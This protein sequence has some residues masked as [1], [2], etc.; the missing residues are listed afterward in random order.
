MKAG[1]FLPLTIV[2]LLVVL[3]PAGAAAADCSANPCLH[4]DC[5]EEESA[6]SCICEPG[7][8]GALC[9]SA[10]DPGLTPA[11]TAT[12]V[13][14]TEGFDD[15]LG[16][17]GFRFVGDADA[18][19]AAASGGRLHLTSDGTQLYHGTDNG[20]L[21]SQTVT[22]DFRAEVQ[23]LGFPVNAGGGYRRSGLTVR[24]G[25]GP[26]DQR[27]Y[28]EYL[29]HHP[30]YNKSALMFD[31]RGASG[32]SELAST[33]L[34]LALPLH[35]AIDRRGDTF[36]VWY[37]SDGINWLKPV[38]AAGGSIGIEMP[39][40]AE[41][42][43]MS[44]S[45]DATV[46]LTSEFDDFE[47]CQPRATRLPP[48]PEEVA[49][50]PGRPLDIVYLLDVTG[51]STSYFG[52]NMTQLDAY[53]YAMRQIDGFVASALPGS[54]SALVTFRGGPAPAYATGAGAT[55]LSS[56]SADFSAAEN[57]A[58][59]IN[60]AALNPSTSS[61]L[62]HGLDRARDLLL[63][64]G[65]PANQPVVV[66]LSDGST[67][68]DFAGRGPQHYKNAEL[69]VLSAETGSGY[70]SVPEM[71]WLGGWNGA[72]ATWDGEPLA[73]AMHQ[74][75]RL[76]ADVPEV[77]VE[78]LGIFINDARPDL[79]GFFADYGSGH[80]TIAYELDAL[81]NGAYSIFDNLDCS[82]ASSCEPSPCNNG[83]CRN[84]PGGAYSCSCLEGWTGE[85]CDEPSGGPGH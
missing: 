52:W 50:V 13:C 7:W 70:R 79:L 35:L 74:A 63:D 49:C 60:G 10:Y 25:A 5:V 68:V 73:D 14:R 38:G 20:G 62:A 31:Y 64:A 46:T 56:F 21:V 22:G 34:G 85:H 16:V 67:N 3:A 9:G 53:R 12:T 26:N 23:L 11:L 15:D 48:R 71:G 36:T 69:Q 4:G 39:A 29:P 76:K 32:A 47:L 72:I 1:I 58:A 81:D 6:F 33:K 77:I 40:T 75:L 42:G 37:S 82:A 28:I 65:D 27:V 24:S 45:Y 18:G 51:G 41:V 78:T 61:P 59:A 57:A 30:V 2:P 80:T 55:V 19:T 8:E 83:V 44:A 84:Q 43:L 66:V 17:L 54:R